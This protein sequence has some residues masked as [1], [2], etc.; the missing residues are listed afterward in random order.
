MI[1][2]QDYTPEEIL[3]ALDSLKNQYNSEE[4]YT[5]MHGVPKLIKRLRIA[6]AN[7]RSICE[8]ESDKQ[9]NYLAN[10][11]ERE[12]HALDNLMGYGGGSD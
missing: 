1:N 5:L 2:T 7:L 8:H 9:A 10:M 12:D 11:Q 4:L 6:E 3:D